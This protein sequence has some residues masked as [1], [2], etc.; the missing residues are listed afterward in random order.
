MKIYKINFK[1]LA[2]FV[3][4]ALSA[5]CSDDYLD[6]PDQEDMLVKSFILRM[7][8]CSELLTE[9]TEECGRHF[10]LNVFTLFQNCHQEIAGRMLMET[11]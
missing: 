6:R 7:S 8:K 11:R 2:V 3:L 9:C 5:S 1:S 10:I 4:L